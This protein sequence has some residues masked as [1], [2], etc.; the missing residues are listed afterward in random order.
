MHNPNPTITDEA[1]VDPPNPF[2]QMILGALQAR[3]RPQGFTGAKHVYAGTVP[4]HVIARRR[5]ANKVARASRRTNRGQ[6]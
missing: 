2:G 5:A 3:R 1:T 4:D 6:R